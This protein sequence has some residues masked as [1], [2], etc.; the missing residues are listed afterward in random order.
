MINDKHEIDEILSLWGRYLF[1]E[2]MK[3]VP[4]MMAAL[5]AIWITIFMVCGHG[6][7]S[8]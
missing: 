6:G 4:F 7:H 2:Y 5:S 1:N 8:S 3:F